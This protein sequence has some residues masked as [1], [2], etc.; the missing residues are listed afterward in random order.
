MTRGEILKDGKLIVK[1][2]FKINSSKLDKPEV[3]TRQ[4]TKLC[5]RLIKT[6]S[7]NYESREIVVGRDGD[8]LINAKHTLILS[9]I[10][11]EQGGSVKDKG[12]KIKILKD[13]NYD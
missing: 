9:F 4:L 7:I 3:M 11:A 1:F 2:W 8:D 5:D 13:Y 6:H 10:C 12:I